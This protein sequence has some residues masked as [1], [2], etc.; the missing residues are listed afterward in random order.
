M[1]TTIDLKKMTMWELWVKFYLRQNE[2]CSL[3]DRTSSSSEKL[4]QRGSGG[5]SKY[6]IL[7]KG[8]FM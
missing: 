7:A 3:V 2:N 8:E 4:L 6:V 1:I 5:R